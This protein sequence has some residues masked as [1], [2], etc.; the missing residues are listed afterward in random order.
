[1][2]LKTA[3]I[4]PPTPPDG[5][6]IV[7]V[8]KAHLFKYLSGDNRTSWFEARVPGR[9]HTEMYELPT[10]LFPPGMKCGDQVVVM[11]KKRGDDE[12]VPHVTTNQ[13]GRHTR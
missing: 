7:G 11:M 4:D 12:T 13:E 10:A 6:P 5:V 1:M 9:V 3:T 2:P 8:T